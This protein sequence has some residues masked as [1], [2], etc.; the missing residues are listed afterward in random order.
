MWDRDT[1]MWEAIEAVKLCDINKVLPCKNGTKEKI[2]KKVFKNKK[3]KNSP[4]KKEKQLKKY[5]KD[6]I[7][8]QGEKEGEVIKICKYCSY[9]AKHVEIDFCDTCGMCFCLRCMDDPLPNGCDEN[10]LCDHQFCSHKCRNIWVHKFV[11]PCGGH[12]VTLLARHIQTS[13]L[14]DNVDC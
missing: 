1:K 2:N 9:S 8:G 3:L 4:K 11:Y 12:C 6:D 10:Q 13:R 14:D 5:S 7:L